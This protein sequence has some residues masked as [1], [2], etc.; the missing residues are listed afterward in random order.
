MPIA[1]FQNKTFQVSNQKKYTFHDF[2]VSEGALVVENQ[3]K[4][5]SKPSSYIKG[6]A[7][8]NISFVVPLSVELGYNPLKEINDWEK[9]KQNAQPA[10]FLL[11]EKPY[12]QNKWL[13]VN[14]TP[15]DIMIDNKGNILKANLKLE[16]QE[17]VREGSPSSS[18]SNGTSSTAAGVSKTTPPSEAIFNPPDKK[19][20]KRDNPNAK[21]AITRGPLL[22]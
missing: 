13:L 6:Q 4:L 22:A 10:I 9:I 11:G 3:E 2:T 19:Y 18:N 20:T 17:H 8:Q 15:V 5:K 14:S 12:G 7:L 16:F 1:V 21:V